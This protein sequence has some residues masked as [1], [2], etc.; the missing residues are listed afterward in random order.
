MSTRLHVVFDGRC[1]FCTRSVGWVRALDRHGR[2]ELH[3]WQGPGVLERFGLTPEQANT[4]VWAVPAEHAASD[5]DADGHTPSRSSTH[6]RPATGADVGAPAGAP[7]DSGVRATRGV[8]TGSATNEP[9]PK[10]TR[11]DSD[12]RATSGARAISAILDTA[13]GGRCFGTFYNLPLVGR[14]VEAVYRWVAAHRGS[15]PGVT[16]WCEQHPGQCSRKH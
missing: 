8:G 5:T 13:L 10:G 3:P 15:F 2:I 7:A 4:S 1:G 11:S 9:A 12:V 16:P 14:T 6:S